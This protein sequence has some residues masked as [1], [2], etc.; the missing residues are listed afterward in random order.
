M[1]TIR[2]FRIWKNWGLIS[3]LMLAVG[4][5]II[6]GGG[7]QTALLLAEGAV[8]HSGRLLR[9]QTETLAFLAPLVADQALVGDYEAIRQLLKQQ[10]KRAQVDRFE[11]VDR[12]GKILSADDPDAKR[13]AP[14][15][16][17]QLV[18]IEHGK[19]SVDVTAG[20]VAYGKLA[21]SVTAVHAEN[22]LWQQFVKQLQ[23]LGVTLFLVLQF[24]W[25]I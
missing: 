18:A 8:E 24:I 1:K 19:Q 4:V 2:V 20:G 13:E 22:R 16:F 12:D 15:W 21:S 3:R 14:E 5:A 11:W 7:V 23:I 6:A 9:E 25:L 10:V 17:A